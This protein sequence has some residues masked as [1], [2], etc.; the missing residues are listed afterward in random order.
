MIAGRRRLAVIALAADSVC[1]ALT[2][3]TPAQ[4]GARATPRLVGPCVRDTAADLRWITWL[5]TTFEGK[6]PTAAS[7]AAWLPSFT[8]GVPYASIATYLA[9]GPGATRRTIRT[10]FAT[11]GQLLQSVMLSSGGMTSRLDKLEAAGLIERRRHE[12]DRRACARRNPS[13]LR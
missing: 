7:T 2:G 4:A 9:K 10:T 6:A 5:S 13:C 12:A 8:K 1:S 3:T 11:L